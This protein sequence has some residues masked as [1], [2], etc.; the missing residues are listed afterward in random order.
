M[1]DDDTE[2][3][4]DIVELIA[5][6][7]SASLNPQAV[8]RRAIPVDVPIDSGAQVTT[9]SVRPKYLTNV[10]PSAQVLS[11]GNHTTSKVEC[12]G[13]I[14]EIKGVVVNKDTKTLISLPKLCT[15]N[16]IPIV[17]TSEKMFLLKPDSVVHFKESCVLMEV[18]LVDG[19]YRANFEELVSKV[20]K[21][22]I[23]N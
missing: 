9:M 8:L 21:I 20:G 15:D 11:F 4:V 22:N 2:I 7:S 5:E 18:P 14:G 10:R 16:G 6:V 13:D 1:Y 12:V 17:C 23:N 19:L 3:D